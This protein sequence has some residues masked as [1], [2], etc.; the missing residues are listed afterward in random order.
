MT[1]LDKML[2]SDLE[3]YTLRNKNIPILMQKFPYIAQIAKNAI[4]KR[5]NLL[6]VEDNTDYIYFI[7]RTIGN[8]SLV[9]Q[10]NFNKGYFFDIKKFFEIL[11]D[12]LFFVFDIP[13]MRRTKIRDKEIINKRRVLEKIAKKLN[14]KTDKKILFKLQQWNSELKIRY[15]YNIL[16][17]VKQLMK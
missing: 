4:D 14:L 3:I 7:L 1:K 16:S 2:I 9:D 17:N 13:E 12:V 5:I 6:M 10:T 11:E 8:A 15:M